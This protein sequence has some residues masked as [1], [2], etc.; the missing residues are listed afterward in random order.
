MS[1]VTDDVKDPDNTAGVTGHLQWES[2]VEPVDGQIASAWR[3]CACGT[4]HIWVRP[5]YSSPSAAGSISHS[6]V[7]W[8]CQLFVKIREPWT[9]LITEQYLK[10]D[11]GSYIT[12]QQSCKQHVVENRKTETLPN[13]STER[14]GFN[15]WLWCKPRSPNML[16]WPSPLWHV[17]VFSRALTRGNILYLTFIMWCLTGL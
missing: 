8:V 9:E 1:R 12:G 5:W 15:L 13:A 2:F 3:G 17:L 10:C 6:H 7:C 11:R 14:R 16:S 4:S